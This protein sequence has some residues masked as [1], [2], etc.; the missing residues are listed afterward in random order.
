MKNLYIHQS[1]RLP[2]SSLLYAIQER[3]FT[4]NIKLSGFIYAICPLI[5]CSPAFACSLTCA[6]VYGGNVQWYVAIQ[7]IATGT[8]HVSSPMEPVHYK[9]SV[10]EVTGSRFKTKTYWWSFRPVGKRGSRGFEWAPLLAFYTP[11]CY[12]FSSAL[13]GPL[14]SL[15]KP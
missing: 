3:V 12:T 11:A 15:V 14:A 9:D 7:I 4:W 8:F 2:T 1:F 5:V 6:W 10:L 13:S